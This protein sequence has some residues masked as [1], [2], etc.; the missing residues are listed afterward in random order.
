MSLGM[1]RSIESPTDPEQQ[2]FI[3]L[4]W[5]TE[6]VLDVRKDLTEEQARQVL[7]EVK[8]RHNASVGVNWDVIKIIADD[9]FDDSDIKIEDLPF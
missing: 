9:M 1:G 4:K 6:D 5:C 7:H 2:D 8:R 3:E